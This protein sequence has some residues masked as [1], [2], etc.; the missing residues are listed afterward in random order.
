MADDCLKATGASTR[1]PDTDRGRCRPRSGCSRSR[2]CTRGRAADAAWTARRARSR[3][4]CRCRCRR[5]RRCRLGQ[6]QPSQDFDALALPPLRPAAFFCWLVPPC[7]ELDL[8][9]DPLPDFLPPRLEEPSEF[10]IAAARPL[11]MPFFLS[12]SYCL[13]FLTLEP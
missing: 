6:A 12:P 8:E 1:G 7:D 5:R 4:W 10:A 9:L 2:C 3:S 11:L 13:S